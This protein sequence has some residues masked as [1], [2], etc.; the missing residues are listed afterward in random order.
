MLD[1]HEA[2]SAGF[3]DTVVAA[4]ELMPAAVAV[5]EQMKRLHL[6]AHANTK[7]KAR[8]A[9]LETLDWAIE[10]DKRTPL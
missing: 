8:K 10:A 2:V 7:V 9:L 5:A 6:T 1:P 4:E 3:L